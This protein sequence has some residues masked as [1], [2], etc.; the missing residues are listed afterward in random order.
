MTKMSTPS[1]L[2]VPLVDFSPFLHGDTVAK[3]TVAQEL[4]D[5]FRNVGFV[6]LRNH[7]VEMERVGKAFWWVS[8]LHVFHFI[9]RT[10]SFSKTKTG[11][12]GRENI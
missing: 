12:N 1:P 6:Y 3:A 7:G 5:A 10:M 4:D 11:A 9:S 2:P 8:E